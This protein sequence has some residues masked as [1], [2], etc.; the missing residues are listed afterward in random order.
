MKDTI[1]SYWSSTVTASIALGVYW[2]AARWIYAVLRTPP[3]RGWLDVDALS[4]CLA[5]TVL[6]AT[7][8]CLVCLSWDIFKT[9]R[10]KRKKALTEGDYP[11]KPG[12][13]TKSN[14]WIGISL[15]ALWGLVGVIGWNYLLSQPYIQLIPEPTALV[16]GETATF[17]VET[18]IPAV[19]ARASRSWTVEEEGMGDCVR[20]QTRAALRDGGSFTVKACSTGIGVLLLGGG[21]M[22]RE[23]GAGSLPGGDEVAYFQI[24]DSDRIPSVWDLGSFVAG[25]ARVRVR[26]LDWRSGRFMLSTS[27]ASAL[28]L[29]NYGAYVYADGGRL[30]RRFDFADAARFDRRDAPEHVRTTFAGFAY[31]Y[32]W[33]PCEKP[34]GGF[35]GISF[36]EKA[37]AGVTDDTPRC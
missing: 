15:V 19:F 32:E 17:T 12:Q 35:N 27:H 26:G 25:E 8:V 5:W 6:I 31:V 11:A 33:E 7:L 9:Y 23:Y 36:V 24:S 21:K 22:Q 29:N 14:A 16:A 28:S 37:H 3:Q 13:G 2:L 18:D 30:L 20:H 34:E 1:V 10:D 4:M